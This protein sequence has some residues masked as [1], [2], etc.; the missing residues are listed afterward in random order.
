M[1]TVKNISDS[2]IINVPEMTVNGN[3]LIT[4]NSTNIYSTNLTVTDNIITLNGNVTGTPT[5]D[6]AIEVNRGS[7]ANVQLRWNESF[8]KWQITND[9]TVFG[10][11]L[12]APLGTVTLNANMVIQN[13][14]VAPSYT[15]GYNTIYAQTP[16]AGGSGLYI[17]NSVK[18]N[19]ELM[20]RAGTLV[21][22]IIFN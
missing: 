11:I 19:Q 7:S 9:G 2:Y 21:Y 13:T 17:T 14:T 3:L 20:T 5:L 12:Y 18:Q 22:S 16:G 1:S 4:G 6:A 8:T 15:A 10:N